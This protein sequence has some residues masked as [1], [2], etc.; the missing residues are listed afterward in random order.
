MMHEKP[1]ITPVAGETRFED[2]EKLT[3]SEAA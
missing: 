3:K 1:G 2:D